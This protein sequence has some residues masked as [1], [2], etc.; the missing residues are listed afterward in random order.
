MRREYS[1]FIALDAGVNARNNNAARTI[2]LVTNLNRADA[3]ALADKTLAANKNPA[4]AFEITFDGTMEGDS[5]VGQCPTA[6]VTLPKF[7]VNARLMRIYRVR[8]DYD[9]NTT[10]V[11]VRG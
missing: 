4:L 7:K 1:D 11:E 10:T 5:L 9:A 2:T 3:Q 6:T 8:T